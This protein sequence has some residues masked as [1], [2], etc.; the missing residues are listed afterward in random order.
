MDTPRIGWVLYDDTC[1]VCRTWVPWWAD[2]LRDRGFGVAPLQADW[3]VE[4]LG[5]DAE[6]LAR[7]IRLLL[8]DGGDIRGAEVYRFVMRRIW[9]A[10]PLY[11]LSLVPGL[12]AVFDW[13][14]R[15]FAKHRHRVSR[16]CR[17]PGADAPTRGPS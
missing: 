6:D 8:V 17:M 4:R 14:Y 11:A 7:D 16:A 13:G 15:T 9:W 3:V 10:W 1:G 5:T 12:R 2:T